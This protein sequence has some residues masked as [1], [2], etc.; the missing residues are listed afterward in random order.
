MTYSSSLSAVSICYCYLS[1]D[2]KVNIFGFWT[3][4]CDVETIQSKYI[5]I[6]KLLLLKRFNSEVPLLFTVSNKITL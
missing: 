2:N 4:V 5:L 3:T 1:C 6:P